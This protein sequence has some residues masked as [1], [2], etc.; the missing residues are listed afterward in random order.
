MS[1]CFIDSIDFSR[2]GA[3][4][5]ALSSSIQPF[6]PDLSFENIGIVYSNSEYEEIITNFLNADTTDYS[7][8]KSRREYLAKY[9][10][11]LKA[12]LVFYWTIIT[13]PRLSIYFSKDLN[14]AKIGFMMDICGGEAILEK[15]ESIWMILSSMIYAC[16]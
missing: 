4:C 16:E 14:K 7:E 12:S 3:R 9:I 10:K 15:K 1:Y 6:L 2:V 8:V 11:V 5:S 13:H